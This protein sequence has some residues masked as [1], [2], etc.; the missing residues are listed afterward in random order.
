MGIRAPRP[1]TRVSTSLA[2][3]VRG[4][5]EQMVAGV[6]A[7]GLV[8]SV[9]LALSACTADGSGA[10]GASAEPGPSSP[11]PASQGDPAGTSA[12]SDSPSPIGEVCPPTDAVAVSVASI[13]P[14]G[15]VSGG[16]VTRIK[17]RLVNSLDTP[18]GSRIQVVVSA[19]PGSGQFRKGGTDGGAAWAA[20]PGGPLHADGKFTFTSL[21][22][23]A[24]AGSTTQFVDFLGGDVT[25]ATALVLGVVDYAD[26]GDQ[27]FPGSDATCL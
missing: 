2:V 17:L 21:E 4:R 12:A 10:A 26:A 5:D 18:T 1:A 22:I 8:L 14:T 23:A 13:T 16:T 24:A 20:G 11:A 25:A 19:T 7:S 6:H 27:L 9:M 15:Q 3:P